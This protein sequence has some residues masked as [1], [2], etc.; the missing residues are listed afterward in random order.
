MRNVLKTAIANACKELGLPEVAFSVERPADMTH[1]DYATNVA[2]V[3]SKKIG[4]EP[5]RIAG[6]I[7]AVFVNQKISNVVSVEIAGP[8]FINFKLSQKFFVDSIQEILQKGEEYGRND[9]LKGKTVMVE[10]TQPNV[11]KPLH[12]GHLMSNVIGEAISRTYEWNGATV[13][14][15]NYQGDVGLHIAKT[16]WGM[17]KK[18]IEPDDVDGVG[19]AYAH[20]HEMYES[21]EVAQ[22]EIIE[23]NKQVYE[24]APEIRDAYTRA[25][26]ASLARFETIYK[27]LGTKFDEYFF[28]SETW[29]KGKVLVEEGLTKGIF[30]KS[31]GAVVFPG[32]K[33]GL[34]TR[35]FLTKEGLTPYEAKDLGLALL[36][37]ERRT[38]DESLTITAVE[39]EQYFN[40]VFKAL[41]L[42]RP[43]FAGKF[44]HTHHGMMTLT[45]GKMS[46]RTGN[47]ITGESL[48]ADMIKAAEEKMSEREGVDA[49]RV[50]EQVAVAAIK[51]MVLKQKSG[52]NIVFDAEKSL[53]IEGDSGPYLQYATVRAMSVLKKANDA[54]ISPTV[55]V[56][57]FETVQIERLLQ[58]FP[59][60]VANALEGFAIHDVAQYLTELA[61]TFNSW[62]AAEQIVNGEDATSPYRIALTKAF[63]T[64]MHNGLA[65][66]ALPVPES[67]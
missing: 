42:L 16:L 60:V 59:E 53:S 49:G 29:Q 50:S 66:L 14:R 4:K 5:G 31:E 55:E 28:E 46:S 38:F 58:R 25:R 7:M 61:G 6:D 26:E 22:A 41:E 47:V 12:I 2:L 64:V 34:H 13:V 57:L 56:P 39:Q 1:G 32:E 27:K 11:L 48:I 24:G 18:G 30:E 17:R 19:Q 40:V 21:D 54:G 15:A 10:Y 36:K 52:K 44:R 62:Y 20:G 67:M 51:Y 45:S 3:L 9:V 8:G 43:E 23:I 37:T 33:Y 63:T 65:L 35:V